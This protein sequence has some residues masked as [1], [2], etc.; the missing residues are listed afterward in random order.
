MKVSLLQVCHCRTPVSLPAYKCTVQWRTGMFHDTRY[1][2]LEIKRPEREAD[3]S[4][5]SNDIPRFPLYAFMACRG[6][7]LPFALTCLM[8]LF[9]RTN[10]SGL[11][12]WIKRLK[13]RYSNCV[14]FQMFLRH[15]S[16]KMKL[17]N[18]ISVIFNCIFIGLSIFVRSRCI[19]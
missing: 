16:L 15:I 11:M 10:S 19:V 9:K 17:V 2:F 3:H 5:W 13:E 14:R 12:R 18:N 4:S 7:H 1:L 6:E 8:T